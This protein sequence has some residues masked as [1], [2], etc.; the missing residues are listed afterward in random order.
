MTPLEF[1]IICVDLRKYSTYDD[2]KKLFED[3]EIKGLYVEK[4]LELR[5]KY[6]KI[7]IDIVGNELFAVLQKNGEI[8]LSVNTDNH[9]LALKSLKPHDKRLASDFSDLSLD[10]ILDK[11]NTHGM[12]SLTAREKYFLKKKS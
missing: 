6:P 7:W 3:N 10:S 12:D 2:L 8:I 4:I 1:K 9:L 5:E 11:I